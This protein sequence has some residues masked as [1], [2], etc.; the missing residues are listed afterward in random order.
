MII[1][2]GL[3]FSFI[4]SGIFSNPVGVDSGSII[5]SITKPLSIRVLINVEIVL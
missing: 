2:D 1:E 5:F 3:R 4:N